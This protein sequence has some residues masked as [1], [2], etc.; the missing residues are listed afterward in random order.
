MMRHVR[1]ASTCGALVLVAACDGPS[2]SVDTVV[3]ASGADLE[4][5]NP[6]VTV[7]PLSRQIQ[8]FALFVTLARY[9][10]VLA[11][12]PY[13]ASRWEWN[14]ARDRL[15]LHL[16]GDLFWHDGDRKSVV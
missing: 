3:Y 1:R 16:R 14:A 15:T 8:R 9:D 2:R 6:L 13:F 11:P 12:E 5:A 4:S 7:H 10:T